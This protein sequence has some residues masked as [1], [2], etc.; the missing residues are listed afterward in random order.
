[1]LDLITKLTE[2]N[3]RRFAIWCA[4]RCKTEIPEIAD[5]LDAIEGHYI[6]GNVDRDQL[7]AANS[8]AYW[9]AYSAAH[10][11]AYR[12]AG[13][14]AYWAAYRAADRDKERKA[15][16]RKIRDMIKKQEEFSTTIGA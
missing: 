6:T 2:T 7:R 13:R 5:Y 8:A 12:A 3:Q 4:R 16:R 1:M 10:W 11:A 15:Q 9:A 14:A